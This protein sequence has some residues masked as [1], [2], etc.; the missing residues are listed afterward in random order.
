MSCASY[1]WRRKT[2]ANMQLPCNTLNSLKNRIFF[3]KKWSLGRNCNKYMYI[4]AIFMICCPNSLNQVSD[5]PDI[6]KLTL[7]LPSSL[8][9]I[10]PWDKHLGEYEWQLRVAQAK[11]ALHGL[12]QNLHLHDFLVKRKK[13]WACGV[14]ENTHSQTIISQTQKKIAACATK[15]H[16]ACH[17]LC[18]LEQ[19]LQKAIS[20]KGELQL[21]TDGDIQGLPSKCLCKVKRALSW[22]WMASGVSDHANWIMVHKHYFTKYVMSCYFSSIALCIHW[23]CTPV[24][25]TLPCSP[26]TVLGQSEQS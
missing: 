7:F 12:H 25:Y 3:I 4:S 2:W 15:Y 23:C 5:V 20:W 24:L 9:Q 21:I 6:H 16:V 1:L 19:T 13:D 22:I 14:C 10:I 18:E 11:D 17:A 8:G 26:R